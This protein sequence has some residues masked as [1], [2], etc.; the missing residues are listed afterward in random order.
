[1]GRRTGGV[2]R[3]TDEAKDWG[4]TDRRGEG[5]EADRQWSGHTWRELA[6]KCARRCQL[7]YVLISCK[8]L[9]RIEARSAGQCHLL[10]QRDHHSVIGAYYTSRLESWDAYRQVVGAYLREATAQ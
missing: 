10:I 7:C 6:A 9:R 5:Q 8:V 2:D 1:M 3:Q 4:E